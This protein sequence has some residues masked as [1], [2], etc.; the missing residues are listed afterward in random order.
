VAGTAPQSCRPIELRLAATRE[1]FAAGFDQLRSALDTLSLSGRPRLSVELVFEEVVANVV[2]HGARPGGRTTVSLEI[3]LH[4][5]AVRLTFLD[6]G[7]AFDPRQRQ[8][9]APARDLEHAETGGRGLMLIRSVSK[10]LEYARTP[11]GHNRLTV[12]V[13]RDAATAAPMSDGARSGV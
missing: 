3:V 2:R 5:D 11:E 8:D 10:D 9:P 6:D 12:V 13:P 1:G 7:I 4:D